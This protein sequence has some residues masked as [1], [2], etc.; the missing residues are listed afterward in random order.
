MSQALM[1]AMQ[2]LAQVPALI[3]GGHDV[4]R[5]IEDGNAALKKMQEENRGPTPA[6][7]AA[8]NSQIDELRAKLHA[9]RSK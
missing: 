2:L 4:A 7:W 3:E 8:L 5:L 9:P 1:F 6:E